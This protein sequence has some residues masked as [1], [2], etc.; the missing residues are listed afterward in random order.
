MVK[1]NWT[2]FALENLNIIGDYIEKD[3]FIY[4]QRV[5]NYLFDAVD[6]LEQNPLAGRK[7]PEFNRADIR[8]LICGNYR[9]IYKIMSDTSI[10]ILTVHHSA[11]LLSSLP[12]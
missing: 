12:D 2:D 7:A 11:R 9:I 4:A 1:I 8:E 6:I 10:D 5:V 3:S